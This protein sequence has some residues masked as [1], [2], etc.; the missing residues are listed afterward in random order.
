MTRIAI[1]RTFAVSLKAFGDFIILYSCLRGREIAPIHLIGSHLQELRR[2][3]DPGWRAMVVEHGS[4]GVPAFYDIKKQGLRQAIASMSILR[5][6]LGKFSIEDTFLFDRVGLKERMIAT[7]R[8]LVGLKRGLNIYQSYNSLF[9]DIGCSEPLEIVH[10]NR[11]VSDGIVRIFPGSRVTGKNIPV[12]LCGDLVDAIMARGFD[13]EIVIIDGEQV[14]FQGLRFPIT[15]LEKSFA[16]LIHKIESS[17]LCICAD[18]LSAHLA[19]LRQRHTFVMSPIDNC[20]W[21]PARVFE[22]GSWSS[23]DQGPTSALR[24]LD[25]LARTRGC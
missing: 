9:A 4:S 24:W 23:F 8:R 12:D 22:N 18:S 16:K 13:V 2:A 19:E 25:R 1:E 14:H 5:F 17:Y 15:I 20:Y 10:Q 11:N 3:V 21:F 7:P 6:E